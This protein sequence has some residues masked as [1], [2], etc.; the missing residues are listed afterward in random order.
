MGCV[1]VDFKMDSIASLYNEES[2]P[3]GR[4]NL[5]IFE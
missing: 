4:E 2:D 1:C 5:M 3:V